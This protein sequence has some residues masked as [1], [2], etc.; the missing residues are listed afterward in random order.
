LTVFLVIYNPYTGTGNMPANGQNRDTTYFDPSTGLLKTFSLGILIAN[1]AWMAWRLLILL[2]AYLGL[3]FTL[4]FRGVFE[5]EKRSFDYADGDNTATKKSR[6]ALGQRPFSSTLIHQPLLEQGVE[7]HRYSSLEAQIYLR[8]LA[9]TSLNGPQQQHQGC[10]DATRRR[11]ASFDVQL[12]HW[13][14]KARAEERLLALLLEGSHLEPNSNHRLIPSS[15]ESSGENQRLA[16]GIDPEPEMQGIDSA[17]ASHFQAGPSTHAAIYSEDN[18]ELTAL[19]PPILNRRRSGEDRPSYSSDVRRSVEFAAAPTIPLAIGAISDGS[20]SRSRISL[21]QQ[22][23]SGEKKSRLSSSS[24]LSLARTSMDSRY[25]GDQ[26]VESDSGRATVGQKSHLLAVADAADP[27]LIERGKEVGAVIS[28]VV[29]STSG[30]NRKQRASSSLSSLSESLR[31]MRSNKS[32]DKIEDPSLAKETKN[33]TTWW[34]SVI[35]RG[36]K[37]QKTYEEQQGTKAEPEAGVTGEAKEGERAVAVRKEEVEESASLKS[38]ESSS[39][40]DSEEKRIWSQ[41]PEQSRK[42]P[43]GL[44]ALELEQKRLSF[45]EDRRLSGEEFSGLSTATREEAMVLTNGGET[46]RPE[47]LRPIEE[48]SYNSHSHTSHDN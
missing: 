34:S 14:W 7:D 27:S 3:F 46:P 45:E 13:A 15:R 18:L 5:R 29:A 12:P 20:P 35:K 48:E 31:F 1:A 2:V 17:R 21:Q 4:G 16:L 9:E 6:E 41:F 11:P 42:F 33:D 40:E 43:P 10:Q 8:E 39:T 47:G 28:P 44:I 32:V 37:D 23:R 22:R 25:N 38:N 30:M 19:R 26:T 24:E 36:S